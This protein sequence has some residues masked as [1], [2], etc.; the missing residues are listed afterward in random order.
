MSRGGEPAKQEAGKHTDLLG[1]TSQDFSLPSLHPRDQTM[2]LADIA[3]EGDRSQQLKRGRKRAIGLL[4]V[5][6][7]LCCLSAASR[8]ITRPVRVYLASARHYLLR[9]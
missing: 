4:G 8:P 7:T 1:D 2:P 5:L 9:R 3:G 6:S